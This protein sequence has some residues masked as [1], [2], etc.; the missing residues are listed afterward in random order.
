[1]TISGELKKK[2]NR[3][4]QTNTTTKN[5]FGEGLSYVPILLGVCWVWSVP[6]RSQCP[7]TLPAQHPGLEFH[8][9]Y[10][11]SHTSPSS[12]SSVSSSS[13]AFFLF[14]GLQGIKKF[15][16]QVLWVLVRTCGRRAVVHLTLLSCSDMGRQVF[17]EGSISVSSVRE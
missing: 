1:M 2:K 11:R 13:S 17:W 10:T 6:S 4:I 9:T 7:S 5:I 15:L 8:L 3:Q 12:S 16:F 14:F